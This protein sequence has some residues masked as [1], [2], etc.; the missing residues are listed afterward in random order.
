LGYKNFLYLDGTYRYDISSTLPTTDWNYGY[1]SVSASFVF[2]E[3]AKASWLDHGKF[4]VSYAQVGNDAPW[5]SLFNTYDQ[6]PIFNGTALY[7]VTNQN[8]DSTIKPEISSG[9]E[10]G[11]EMYFLKKRLGFDIALYQANTDNQIFPVAVSYATGYSSKILN[12]GEVS[13]K[14]IEITLFGAPVKKGNF[15]WDVTLNWSR[16]IN[17]VVS[18]ES[19]VENLQLALLQ[20]GVTINARVGEPYGTIQ[21]TDFIYDDN[22]QRVVGSNGYYM[23]TPKSDIVIGNINPDWNAGLMNRFSYKNWMLSVLVDWQQGGSVFSL[24]LYYGMGTGLYE[25]TDYTN[26]LGNPV[27][28]SLEDGGGLILDGV[29]GDVTFNPDGT[30]TV[31]NTA[32][33]TIRVP[34]DNYRALGWARNP[35]SKFVYDATYIKLREVVLTY[36][37]PAKMFESSQFFNGASFSLVGNNLWII[38]KDLP[39]ADPE[40]GHTAG[41]IQGW[42]SGV[43]PTTRNI[44]FTVNLQF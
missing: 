41:N 23:R 9:F 17:E 29:T 13:N 3:L 10:G 25:E 20:G 4:R 14:G 1:P 33:N 12:A 22:G 6:N 15:I 24:D 35:N 11:L 32:T 26:D 21:G 38:S 31:T 43:M 44:G 5:G 7:S 8:N 27:R 42:Q 34:G 37:L 16:N 36:T 19:G 2:S 30:Y 39:H 40:T 28:N 18:L